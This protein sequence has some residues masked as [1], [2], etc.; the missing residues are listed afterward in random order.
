MYLRDKTEDGGEASEDLGLYQVSSGKAYVKGYE[1]NKQNTE[2]V[3]FDKPRTVKTLENQ[4]I[5]YNTGASL[6]LNRVLGSPEVGIGNTYIV[7]LRDTKNRNS[8]C[9][10]YH[11]CSRRGNRF[12]KSI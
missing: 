5:T 7:S 6:R 4:S 3:D 12:S 1:V 10:K 9:S 11:V 2:F 8:K